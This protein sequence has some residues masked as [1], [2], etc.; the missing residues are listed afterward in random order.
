MTLVSLI[1]AAGLAVIMAGSSAYPAL[2]SN[3]CVVR[4]SS[5][6]RPSLHADTRASASAERSSSG[7]RLNR[8][9]VQ[10]RAKSDSRLS[11]Q[12]NSLVLASLREIDRCGAGGYSTQREAFEA[13]GAA[14]RW[15]E[16]RRRPCFNPAGARP[17]FCSGAVYGALLSALMKWDAAQPV[18]RISRESWLALFPAGERDGVRPWGYANANGP[19]FAALVHELGAGYSF[20]D[21]RLARPGD[22]MKIWWSEDIGALEHGHLVIFIRATDSSVTFWS[23]NMPTGGARGGY[24]FKTIA[25][26]EAKRVLFTRITNPAAFNRAASV[27]HSP[28]LSGL[29]R[30]SVT[31][32]D[33]VTRCG[34]RGSSATSRR[35]SS[36]F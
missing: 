1:R 20:V 35:A 7:R 5:A 36:R 28:W 11:Q 12:W 9:S 3:P 21:Y 16:K 13:L 2:P 27:G 25:R 30:H 32:E 4:G 29:L 22:V 17:S 15:D 10:T 23:S 33:C 34:I 31:W 26:S 14:F 18:R 6:G 24:G 8:A 19:G